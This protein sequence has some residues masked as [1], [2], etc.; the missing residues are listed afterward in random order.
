[1]SHN[2]PAV[3]IE[4]R[5]DTFGVKYYFRGFFLNYNPKS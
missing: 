5:F 1:M 2:F 4:F 3:A